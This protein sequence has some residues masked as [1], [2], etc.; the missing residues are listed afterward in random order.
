MGK[1]SKCVKNIIKK[2][3]FNMKN[4]NDIVGVTK[5]ILMTVLLSFTII[6]TFNL[7]A[8]ADTLN[9][10]SP[11]S[12][13]SKVYTVYDGEKFLFK[14]NDKTAKE[15]HN[16]KKDFLTAFNLKIDTKD[17]IL[18][19]QNLGVVS[20]ETTVESILSEVAQKYIQYNGL[21]ND[22][23]KS[24]QI[25]T[26]AKLIDTKNTI[27][28]ILPNQCIA[29]KVLDEINNSN[30]INITLVKE[31]DEAVKIDPGI[32]IIPDEALYYGQNTTIEGEAGEKLVKKEETYINGEKVSDK[33]ISETILIEAKNK[34]IYKGA[35]NPYDDGIAFLNHPTRGGVMTSGYGERWNAFHKGID[36]AGNIGDLVNAAIDGKVI[37]AQY[38]DGGYGNLIILEHDDN[39]LTYYAHLSHIGVSVG[40]EVIK[41]DKIGEVGNTG[42]STGPHLH[43]EL[44]V[45]DNPVD[46]SKYIL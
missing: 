23:I 31:V 42:F 43:F 41:G 7:G 33:K 46:P 32:E 19:N 45:N 27:D 36:I 11:N 38:N 3:G 44:R 22:V 6:T 37:Y 17:F 35:K 13:N 15:M 29:D 5:K 12:A 39:M 25:E 20:M 18:N 21:S 1:G 4:N 9:N 34:V 8:Y 14:D 26:N 2:E 30:T 28:K 10:A 16:V 40:D 24:I